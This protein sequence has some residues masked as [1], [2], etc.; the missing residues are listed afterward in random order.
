MRRR[1]ALTCVKQR[2]RDI[3][4]IH[5]RDCENT[6]SAPPARPHPTD[7]RTERDN[8]KDDQKVYKPVLKLV[9]AHG[10]GD[11]GAAEASRNTDADTA[12][13]AADHDVPEH[14]LLAIARGEVEDDD[15]GGDDEDGAVDEE[16]GG[17]EE[18]LEL[19]DLA[20]GLF[21]R[22]CPW[23]SVMADEGGG[24]RERVPLSAMMTEPN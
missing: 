3:Q 19:G 7:G 5:L 17:E 16:A 13:H 24:V 18:F 6:S 1:R 20:N 9:I 14:A 11:D 8:Y 10:G 15:E 12:D 22:A 4:V 2:Q 23:V 21:L